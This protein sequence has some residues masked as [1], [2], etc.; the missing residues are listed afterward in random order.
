MTYKYEK[1]SRANVHVMGKFVMFIL[2]C[3]FWAR[4]AIDYQTKFI[5]PHLAFL[6]LYSLIS[7]LRGVNARES[8]PCVVIELNLTLTQMLSDEK[9]KERMFWSLGFG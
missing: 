2:I 4:A 7:R 3:V 9:A 6:S 1:L 5:L 8:R